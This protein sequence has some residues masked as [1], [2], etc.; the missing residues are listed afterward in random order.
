MAYRE[1]LDFDKL[2]KWEKDLINMIDRK[3]ASWL[4]DS[5]NGRTNSLEDTRKYLLNRITKTNSINDKEKI[6]SNNIVW[7]AI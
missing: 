3:I 7:V 2:T 4:E 5:K 1:E 6:F